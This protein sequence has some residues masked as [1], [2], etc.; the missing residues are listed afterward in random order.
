MRAGLGTGISKK[1]QPAPT[2][3]LIARPMTN[4]I[5]S[6]RVSGQTLRGSHPASYHGLLLEE[7]HLIQRRDRQERWRSLVSWARRRFYSARRFTLRSLP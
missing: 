3:K 1:R 4:F 2:A 5:C 7:I 6:P